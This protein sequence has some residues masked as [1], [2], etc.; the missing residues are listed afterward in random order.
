MSGPSG[1][2]LVTRQE[3]P[4]AIAIGALT[5]ATWPL[6]VAAGGP[7]A[8]L[9]ALVAHVSGMLAG[10]GVLLLLLLTARVPA[11]ERDLGADV[12]AR[13]H[14]RGGRAVVLLV[15]VHAGTAVAAV[16]DLRGTGGLSGAWTVLGMPWLPAATLGT[17]VMLVVAALSVRAARARISHERWHGAHLLMHLA[18]ALGFAHQL[19]GPDLAGHR[20]LQV[21]WSLAYAHVLGLVLVHRVLTPLRQAARHRLRVVGVHPEGPGVVSIVVEGEHLEEL[22]AQAGQFFR[23]RFLT[24][25]HWRT[26]HPFSL[27][28]APTGDLL[29]LTVKELG[30]GS[31]RLQDLPVGTWVVTEGPYGAVTAARRTRPHVLLVAG[32]VGITPMRALLETLPVGDGQDVL[33]VYRARTEQE[34][35]FRAELDHLVRSGGVRVAHVVGEDP[36]LLDARALLRLVPDVADRDVY[37]CGPPGLAAAVRTSL[38]QAGLP[39]A[40]LHEE[41]FAL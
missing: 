24:P 25:D 15:V 5:V 8:P 6:L 32:G 37:L 41:R 11:L 4:V 29:R 21:L 36:T 31:R 12:L 22:Q 30:D 14:A 13:W 9:V 17:V 27:S 3:A 2:P 7:G 19:A 23:W 10:A 18:V 28:A 16:A 40:R 39:A 20:W 1:A 33:L 26:A 38:R 35:L 34:L